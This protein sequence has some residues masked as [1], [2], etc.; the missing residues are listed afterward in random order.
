MFSATRI[1]ARRNHFSLI[2]S[3]R[4]LMLS[5]LLGLGLCAGLCS[6][7]AAQQAS[8]PSDAQAL[9]QRAWEVMGGGQTAGMLVHYHA[10]ASLSQNYQSDRMYPP[11]LDFFQEQE[12]WFNPRTAVSGAFDHPVLISASEIS[13]F[14]P[15]HRRRA[16]IFRGS[17]WPAKFVPLRHAAAL[18][19]S[20]AGDQ[21]LDEGRPSARQRHR[22]IPRFRPYGACPANGARRAASF[23]RSQSGFPVKLELTAKHYLWGQRHIEYVYTTW[24]SEKGVALPGAS[25]LL[26]DGTTEISQTIGNRRSR[27]P[28]TL[29]S[30]RPAELRRYTSPVF[31]AAAAPGYAGRPG[32]VHPAKSRLPRSCHK[33]R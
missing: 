16:R 19:E 23:S 13:E 15:A 28:L 7:A 22:T 12:S 14:R 33:N 26:A 17:K 8:Q 29:P 9:L 2:H 10:S 32:D 30:A 6:Q 11:F 18:P 24:V 27:S 20:V 5:C 3:I 31:A 25:Y 1:P 21:R 4:K